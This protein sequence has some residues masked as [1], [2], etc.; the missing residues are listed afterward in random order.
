[1]VYPS[2]QKYRKKNLLTTTLT[3]NRNTEADLVEKIESVPNKSRYL[4]ELIRHDISRSN[5]PSDAEMTPEEKRDWLE[6]HGYIR[7]VDGVQYLSLEATSALGCVE[8]RE[9]KESIA[10]G[11]VPR[12]FVSEMRKGAEAVQNIYGTNDM[13]ELLYSIFCQK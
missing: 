12:E 13:V 1:M 11:V 7:Q 8:P 2:E 9:L 5:H 4:K 3:L 6:E 10:S